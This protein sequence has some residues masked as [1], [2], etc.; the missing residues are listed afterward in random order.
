VNYIKRTH[1]SILMYETIGL[2]LT[3][4]LS[5]RLTSLSFRIK[6]EIGVNIVR[7]SCRRNIPRFRR[8]IKWLQE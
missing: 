8:D 1:I 3:I 2:S 5:L 6:K 4:Y 7:D